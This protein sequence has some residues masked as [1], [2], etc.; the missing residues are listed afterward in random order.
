MDVPKY[1]LTKILKKII[2]LLYEDKF[3]QTSLY[4]NINK[5]NTS[6][7]IPSALTH[8]EV[9]LLSEKTRRMNSPSWW[10]SYVE[11]TMTYSPGLRRKRWVTSRRLMYAL[12]RALEELDVKNSFCMCCLFPCI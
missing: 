8:S 5:K 4:D 9:F 2:F 11:G 10:G 6:P 7:L 1:F 3:T 12:E